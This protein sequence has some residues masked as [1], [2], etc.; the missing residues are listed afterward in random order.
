M[1]DED[2]L[3]LFLRD[4]PP[5]SGDTSRQSLDNL[6]SRVAESDL[7]GRLRKALGSSDADVKPSRNANRASLA[8]CTSQELE[9]IAK[10]CIS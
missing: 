9:H 8:V 6:A 4:E 5:P 1:E 2:P 7:A 3:D 10:V